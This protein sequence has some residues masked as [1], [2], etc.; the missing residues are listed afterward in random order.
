MR[1]VFTLCSA[2][3]WLAVGGVVLFVLAAA[4]GV[5]AG[6]DRLLG[7]LHRHVVNLFQGK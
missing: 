5:V 4:Y 1:F 2:V 3:F 7:C 6:V